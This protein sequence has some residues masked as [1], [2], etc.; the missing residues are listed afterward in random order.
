MFLEGKGQLTFM[1]AIR[2]G[3]NNYVFMVHV[4]SNSDVMTAGFQVNNQVCFFV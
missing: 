1:H 3:N 2:I 4:R